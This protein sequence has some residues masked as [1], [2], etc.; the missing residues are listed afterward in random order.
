MNVKGIAS[1]LLYELRN[2]SHDD[3][4]DRYAGH[5]DCGGKLRYMRETDDGVPIPRGDRPLYCSSGTAC[6][7]DP[8]AVGC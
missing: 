3:L 7:W 5:C 2:V 8:E 4:D 1:S 6:T